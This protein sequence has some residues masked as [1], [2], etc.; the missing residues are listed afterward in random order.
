M[1]HELYNAQEITNS[2]KEHD[3]ENNSNQSGPA[4]GLEDKRRDINE[5]L[6]ARD[7]TARE[8]ENLLRRRK[9]LNSDR[10]AAFWQRKF[11]YR[12]RLVYEELI[13]G[14]KSPKCTL[15]LSE[16]SDRFTERYST[17]MGGTLGTCTKA[18]PTQVGLRE[19]TPGDIS[20]VI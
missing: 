7:L 3:S 11:N 12:A 13:D 10:S 4:N 18:A 20:T 1:R 15:P 2:T 9:R 6:N 19:I 8:R 14:K 16:V 17:D 5:R